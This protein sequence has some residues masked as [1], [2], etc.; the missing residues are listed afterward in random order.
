MKMLILFFLFHTAQ[1]SVIDILPCQKDLNSMSKE[2]K[3]TGDWK[4]EMQGGLK[5]FFYASP[6]DKIGEWVLTRSVKDGSVISKISQNGRI[7]VSFQGKDCRKIAKTYSHPAPLKGHKIDS[8]LQRFVSKNKEGVFYVWSPRMALSQKGISEIK[9]AAKKLKLPLMVLLD[10]EVSEDEHKK[11]TKLLGKP[12]TQRVD[13][14]EL[15]MRNVSQHFP[16]L[17]VFKDSKILSEVKYGY[18]KSDRYKSDL[19]RMLGKGK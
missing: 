1:A 5:N 15:K 13:S 2:W 6:T 8:D 3:A 7:E 4:K 16:A 17:L 14:L 19:I 11:L 10:K 9:D 18:E 12:S